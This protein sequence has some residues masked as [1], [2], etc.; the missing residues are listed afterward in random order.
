M[1]SFSIRSRLTFW[2]GSVV[3]LILAVG[4]YVI[5]QTARS[6]LYQEIDQ[7]LASVLSLEA[8]ELEI[9]D[10]V[11]VHEWLV[12]IIN[13]DSRVDSTYIQVWDETSGVTTR[14]PAIGESDLPRSFAEEGMAVTSFSLPNGHH[15]RAI[16][17]RIDPVIEWTD[18]LL[19]SSMQIAPA[20]HYMAIA[21]DVEASEQA[22][23]QLAGTLLLGLV[24]ALTISIVT[25][26]L[27]I[28]LS[29][30]PLDRL[31][32]TINQIDVKNPKAVFEVPQDLPAE[33][34]SLV[35]QYRELFSRINLTRDRER[36]FSAN[37]AHE[38]RTPLAGIEAT[39]EQALAIERDTEE[40]KDRIAETLQIANKMG[41]LINR[42]MWFSRLYNRSESVD[43]NEVD[44]QS[45]IEIRLAILNSEIAE[46][47]LL[48]ETSFA[49]DLH[50][51]KSDETLLGILMNNLIGNAVAHAD[52]G[53]VV[54][55]EV[56]NQSGQVAVVISNLCRSFDKAELSRIFQPFYRSD[57]SRGGDSKH[58]G[59][60]LALSQEIAK[61]LGLEIK[62]SFSPESVFSVKVIF[63]EK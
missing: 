21:F 26:R 45:I 29:F 55:V 56:R 20:P 8:L 7:N 1:R 54:S 9:I 6:T 52:K 32:K 36:E 11:I 18:P 2:I 49:P 5:Y 62:V 33:V 40:Y 10:G 51:V 47:D 25:I 23:R 41:G 16:G 50:P 53:S 59:I 17:K 63:S 22:L 19:E 14:S 48:I 37:V 39:L 4:S 61:L 44:L 58:S 13:D 57:S 27:I 38:L 43:L 28:A 42:L 31:E 3:T 15:G 30:R 46:R 60:G 34:T 24:F 35:T 12:D